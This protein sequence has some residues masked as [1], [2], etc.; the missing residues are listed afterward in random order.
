MS[1]R[2]IAPLLA[3]AAVLGAGAAP[4]AAD[5]NSDAINA[6][7]AFNPENRSTFDALERVKD[8]GGFNISILRTELGSRDLNRRWA[9]MYLA[10]QEAKT[11]PD[12]RVLG[13]R[14]RDRDQSIRAMAAYIRRSPACR[15]GRMVGPDAENGA[16]VL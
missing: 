7:R 2:R 8:A 13:P 11:A 5:P 12:F 14:L 4:A 9:A 15:G 1:V 6:V 16:R 10:Y 3:V